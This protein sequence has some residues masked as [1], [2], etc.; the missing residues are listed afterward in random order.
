MRYMQ[1]H[2]RLIN[3]NEPLEDPIA[4][5]ANL[6]DASIVFIVSMMIAL[7]MAYNMMDL[8]DPNSEVTMTKK[9]ADG[10]VEMMTK[11]GKQIKV[12]KVTDKELAGSGHRLG[13]AY[14]LEDGKVVYVPEK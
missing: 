4:G 1:R 6:F 10:K 8:L 9:T 7:F 14:Q 13:T 12:T 11:K 3:H 5:V 2:K